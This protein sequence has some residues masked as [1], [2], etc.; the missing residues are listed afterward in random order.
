VTITTI[1]KL[2]FC[3]YSTILHG[4]L[5]ALI[6]TSEYTTSVGDGRA[7]KIKTVIAVFQDVP[8]LLGFP[9]L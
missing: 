2:N 4:N 1:I 5:I 8:A 9:E 3:H 7:S 6:K